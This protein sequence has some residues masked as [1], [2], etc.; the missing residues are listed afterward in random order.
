MKDFLR[1]R[2][3]RFQFLFYNSFGFDLFVQVFR[4]PAVLTW[5]VVDFGLDHVV[6]DRAFHGFKTYFH[7]S[8]PLENWSEQ[9]GGFGVRPLLDLLDLTVSHNPVLG[10]RKGKTFLGCAGFLCSVKK[11]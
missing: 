2:Y 7:S 9:G 4:R 10:T 11:V 8:L 3:R 6:V 1:T 5:F